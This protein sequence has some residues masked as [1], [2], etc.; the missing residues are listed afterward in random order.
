M[1]VPSRASGA[2]RTPTPSSRTESTHVRGVVR[3]AT[4]TAV[5][6]ACWRTLA[7][8]SWAMRYSSASTRSGSVD[9]VAGADVDAHAGLGG[10]R[11]AE[12]GQRLGQ[13]PAGQRRGPQVE[14]R[15]PRVLQA[16]AGGRQ[17]ALQPLA[18][19]LGA[20]LQ[21]A[22]RPLD[23]QADRGQALGQRV[24]D[25]A[26]EAGALLGP[27][28]AGALLGQARP[29]DGDPDLRRRSSRAAAAPRRASGAPGRPGDVHDPRAPRVL[30]VERD[31]GVVAQPLGQRR[32]LR[33]DGRAQAAALE[34]V[35]VGRA[36][37]RPRGTS[38]CTGTSAR[39]SAPAP[40]G[41]AAGS[42]RRRRR[43]GR[44]SGSTQP[45]PA[46]RAARAGRRPARA[47]APAPARRRRRCS[48][49]RRWR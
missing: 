22:Q 32:V 34:H 39:S 40:A 27:G 48:A 25:L 41:T 15:A 14:H 38:R 26:G 7:S 35:D 10:E 28:Q 20:A 45:D 6:W 49:P 18:G 31:A 11:P 37:A 42:G 47:C 5:A 4:S 13:R 30:E 9:A 24:V 46:G 16:L 1:V 19:A 17:R 2:A 23:V 44:V 43:T 12:R 29:L 33:L 3:S 21:V 8:A 36:S